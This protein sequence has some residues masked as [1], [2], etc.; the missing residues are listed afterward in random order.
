MAD[1]VLMPKMGFDMA[2]GTLV[3]WVRAEGESIQKGEILAEIETDKATVE[4]ES[5]YTG[6]IFKQLVTQGTVVPI[7]TP[8]ALITG[9]DEILDDAQVA[10]LIANPT[11]PCQEPTPPQDTPELHP[12]EVQKE[13][14][15]VPVK[16]SPLAKRIAREEGVDLA[17]LKGSGPEGR[18]VRRDVEAYSIS[19]ESATIP[20]GPTEPFK[21]APIEIAPLVDDVIPINKLR[22]TIARRMTESKQ[23]I[24]HIYL[25]REFNV[26][27]LVQIRKELNSILPEGQKLTLNDFIVKACALSLRQFPNLNASFGGTQIVRHGAIHIGVA[28]A[29]DGGLMTVVCRNADQKSL[30]T[31][32]AEI[33]EKAARA[34]SRKVHPDDIEGSTFTISNLGMYHIEEFAAIINPPEV[35][36]LA[37]GTAQSVPVV[38][39]GELRTGMR[40]K[41]TLSSDHRVTDGAE[42][43]QYLEVLNQ[44]LSEPLRLMI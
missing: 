23:Q 39:D 19:K 7:C 24:P 6:I 36:I 2:E 9:P 37:V 35:A 21:P 5:A 10:E 44:F 16:A 33:R 40:M 18:V 28:V 20:A 12:S 38:E 41:A 43:A 42:S 25:T 1:T 14:E 15:S 29:V 32:S 13:L 27:G 8:I 17:T 26:D 3:R 11:E 30:S 4:I 31:L 34:R 22:S